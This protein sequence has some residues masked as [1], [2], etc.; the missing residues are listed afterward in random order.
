MLPAHSYFLLPVNEMKEIIQQIQLLRDQWRNNPL[1]RLMVARVRP[2]A[3]WVVVFQ[4]AMS[5]LSLVVVVLTA[6]PGTGTFVGMLVTAFLSLLGLVVFALQLMAPIY[7][8]DWAYKQ[9]WLEDETIRLTRFTFRERMAAIVIPM[10]FL[11]A[12]YYLPTMLLQPGILL[13]QALSGYTPNSE[14]M[15]GYGWFSR[16]AFIG[17]IESQMIV[18]AII[19]ALLYVVVIVRRLIQKRDVGRVHAR[20]A[21][22]MI[23]PYVHAV[24]IVFIWLIP[25]SCLFAFPVMTQAM[26]TIGAKNPQAPILVDQVIADLARGGAGFSGVLI[27]LLLVLVAFRFLNRMRVADVAIART[28]LFEEDHP[29]SDQEMPHGNQ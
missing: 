15:F 6:S 9:V 3:L 1:A 19:T 10:L 14:L 2:W 24:L 25:R 5:L 11:L 22:F 29:S 21:W 26:V 20:S 27:D 16:L 13:F 18:Y 28:M 8:A 7:Y 12:A 23:S 4:V 17:M